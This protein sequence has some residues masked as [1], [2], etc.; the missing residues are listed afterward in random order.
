MQD[1]NMKWKGLESSGLLYITS[2]LTNTHYRH[3]KCFPLSRNFPLYLLF[4]LPHFFKKPFFSISLTLRIVSRDAPS[5]SSSLSSSR[6]LHR[7]K[8]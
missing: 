7:E 3:L 4:I 2:H 5:E 6:N 1:P 8:Y